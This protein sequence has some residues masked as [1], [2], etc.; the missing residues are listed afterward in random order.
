MSDYAIELGE[1]VQPFTCT[2]CGEEAVT[3]SG[4]VSE[5]EA[6]YAIYFAALMTPHEQISARLTISLGGWGDDD[7]AERQWAYIEV[8]PK[9]G[10]SCAM[11]IRDAKESLH[12]NEKVLGTPMS[13]AEVLKSP[14]RDEF[15]AV[16]DYIVFKDPAVKSYLAGDEVSL[17][18][19]EKPE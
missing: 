11:M 2:H 12:K 10:E 3:V 19:R 1:T 13:R 15:Y 6:P 16:A 18:G 8:R 14:L 5:Q 4:S 17:V 9:D 7:E